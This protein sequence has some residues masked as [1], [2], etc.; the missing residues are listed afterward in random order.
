MCFIYYE[1]GNIMNKIY[2]KNGK[3]EGDCIAYYGIGGI[4]GLLYGVYIVK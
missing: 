2:Y 1:S 3:R 4:V